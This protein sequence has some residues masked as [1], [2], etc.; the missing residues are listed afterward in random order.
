MFAAEEDVGFGDSPAVCVLNETCVLPA[1][2]IR[3]SRVV[4]PHLIHR[5]CNGAIAA[6]DHWLALL[7]SVMYISQL[8]MV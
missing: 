6:A 1:S 5:L 7:K 8:H 4:I 2:L 3:V